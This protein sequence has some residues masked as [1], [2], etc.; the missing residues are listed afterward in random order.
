MRLANFLEGLCETCQ[1]KNLLTRTFCARGVLKRL[2]DRPAAND[3]IG[4][5]DSGVLPAGI[6]SRF[7][8]NV[9]GIRFHV[10]EAGFTSE[11]QIFSGR[12]IEP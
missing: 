7:V 8:D 9:N 6:R 10:L 12:T 3:A 11:L 2:G 5:Y 4:P 1:E